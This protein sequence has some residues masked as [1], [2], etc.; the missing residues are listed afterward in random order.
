MI[1]LLFA[2]IIPSSFSYGLI[3]PNGCGKSTLLAVIANREITIPK[4]FDIFLL[5]REMPPSDKTALQSVMEVDE[6]RCRLEQEAGELTMAEGAGECET[7]CAS[8]CMCINSSATG[9]ANP[10]ATLSTLFADVHERLME[11]YERLDHLDVSRA[12]ANAATLLHGLG[13]TAEM[14]QKQV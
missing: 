7:T 6:E 3:G 8:V 11:I 9:L 14:Q 2:P 4:H 13:F 12:E 1:V 5:Q 10:F